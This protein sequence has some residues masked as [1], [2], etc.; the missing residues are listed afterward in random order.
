M[1][2][3][4]HI[5][6]IICIVPIAIVAL[7]M[8]FLADWG[9]QGGPIVVS[10]KADIETHKERGLTFSYVHVRPASHS[11]VKGL[12][13]AEV[14]QEIYHMSLINEEVDDPITGDTIDL[15]LTSFPNM[16]RLVFIGCGNLEPSAVV[17]LNGHPALETL[18][19]EGCKGIPKDISGEFPRIPNVH[20]HWND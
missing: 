4:I 2:D 13:D 14:S 6:V 17:R 12:V 20:V 18:R 1:S 7:A 19:F 8:L 9:E 5:L 10:Q 11:L 15:L 3:N 16:K